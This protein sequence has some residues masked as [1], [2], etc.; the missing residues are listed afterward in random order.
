VERE[1]AIIDSTYR[2]CDIVGSLK[3]RDAKISGHT[4]YLITSSSRWKLSSS[5][6]LEA[7]V[8]SAQVLCY[9]YVKYVLMDTMI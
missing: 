1:E 9:R 7:L 8:V 2:E 3:S 4:E 6:V 5:R